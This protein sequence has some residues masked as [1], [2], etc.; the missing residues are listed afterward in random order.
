MYGSGGK[1]NP[2]DAIYQNNG[3]NGGGFNN[4]WGQPSGP[5]TSYN[6]WGANN[7]QNWPNNWGN[8]TGGW[9]AKSPMGGM[10]GIMT[11]GGGFGNGNVTSNI[12]SGQKYVGKQ[13]QTL[14]QINAMFIKVLEKN[15]ILDATRQSLEIE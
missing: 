10:G 8:T 6:A 9:G 15:Q 12:A 5:Q 4:N 7:Q 14:N 1:S 13:K 3:N 2:W 11:S